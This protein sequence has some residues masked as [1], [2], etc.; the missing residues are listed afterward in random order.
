MGSAQPQSHQAALE[1]YTATNSSK[2]QLRGTTAVWSDVNV[3]CLVVGGQ[4][5]K[6][7]DKRTCTIWIYFYNSQKQ[8]IP[9][10]SGCIPR[11]WNYKKKS[12][13]VITTKVGVVITSEQERGLWSGKSWGGASGVLATFFVSF[14]FSFLQ[15]S[16]LHSCLILNSLNSTF[17]FYAFFCIL[18]Y[19]FFFNTPARKKRMPISR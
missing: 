1:Y 3:T 14:F 10:C 4:S 8:A 12:N 18:L 15:R 6:A 16:W 19:L 17:V 13:E 5:Q 11:W 9:Y 7:E 2:L